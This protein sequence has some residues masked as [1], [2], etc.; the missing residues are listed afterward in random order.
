M[1]IRGENQNGDNDIINQG[2]RNQGYLYHYIQ[3]N[4]NFHR[5]PWLIM[6]RGNQRYFHIQ[7]N[8]NT[9]RL[10]RLIMG[11]VILF[12]QAIENFNNIVRQNQGSHQGR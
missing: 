9:P 7:N 11:Q 12:G 6:G 8:L 10:Q 3:N 5:F 4:L 1:A 2:Q